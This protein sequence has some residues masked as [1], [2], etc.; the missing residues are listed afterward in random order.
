MNKIYFVNNVVAFSY[1]CSCRIYTDAMNNRRAKNSL[2]KIFT[3]HFIAR[4]RKGLLKVC[5]WGGVGDRT[6][7]AIFWP[8]LLWP[9]RCVFLV[10]LMLNRRSRGHSAGWWLSLRHLI[11]IFSGPQLIRAQR[12][13]RPD[14][15][16]PTTSRLPPTGTRLNCLDFCLD[17]AM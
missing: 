15:A 5:V 9:S 16:F 2:A 1:T 17:W 14:V 7:T 8:S 3:Y 12:P 10:P 6:E 4:V 11:S 13:L